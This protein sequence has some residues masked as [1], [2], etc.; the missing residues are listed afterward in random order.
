M[1]LVNLAHEFE[2]VDARH[3]DVGQNEVYFRVLRDDKRGPP[4]SRAQSVTRVAHPLEYALRV[5]RR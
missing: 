5:P 2:A 1:G 3:L 4:S